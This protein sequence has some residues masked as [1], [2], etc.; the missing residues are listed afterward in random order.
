MN[1]LKIKCLCL[2]SIFLLG[3]HFFN[4]KAQIKVIE[5]ADK[6][7]AENHWVD[8]VY[9]QLTQK[10][11]IAQLF[12]AAAYSNRGADHEKEILKLIKDYHIGGLIFFQGGPVRQAGLTNKYQKAA[13]VPLLI[14]ID[15]E[16][17]LGMRLDSTVNFPYQMTLGA[18]QNDSL[19]YE[20]GWQLAE[21]FKRMGMHMNF[22]PVVDVNNNPS[23]P[24]INYRSFGENRFNVA[25][26]GLA[27]VRG[28]QDNGVL[29]TAK[30]FP[31]HGDTGTDSHY[32]LPVIKHSK[33][34]LDSLELFP[35]KSL[36]DGG[37]SSVMIA[38]MNVL[39]L[40]STKN[41]PSTLSRPIVTDLLKKDLGFKGLVVT[42]AMNMKGVT[43]HF[44]VGEA[45]VRAIEAGNDLL[46]FTE[47]IP[48]AIIAI[49]ESIKN[50][51]ITREDI[52]KRCKKLLRAKYRA[53]LNQLGSIDLTNL[54]EDLNSP[55]VRLINRRL[56]RASLTVLKNENKIIPVKNLD[57][58]KVASISIGKSKRTDFQKTLSQYMEMDHYQLGLKSSAG[59]IQQIQKKLASYDLVIAG[60][61]QVRKRPSNNNAYGPSLIKFINELAKSEKTIISVFR[62]AYTLD[63]YKDISKAKGLVLTYQESRDAQ[64]LA[65]QLIFGGTGASGKLPVSINDDF[66]LG[67]GLNVKGSIRLGYTLPEEMG[68][69]SETLNLRIDSLVEKAIELKA[70]PGAQVLIA[71]NGQVVFHK[72]YGF[73]SYTDTIPVRKKD[74]Y[75]MASITKV[76]TSLPILMKLIDEEKFNL[77]D[78]LRKYWPSFKGTNKGDLIFRD[79]LAHQAQLKP[80]IPYWESTIKKNGGFKPKTLKKDSSANYP[81]KVADGLF[82]HKHYKKKIYKAI[83]KSPLEAQKKYKYSGLVFYL[84]PEII[85]NITNEDFESYLYGNFYKPLGASTLVYNPYKYFP[86]EQVVPTESDFPFRKVAI[87]GRVH[88]EGA[89]MMGGISSNAG[90]FGNAN[91]MAKLFQ[92]YLNMGEYGGKRYVSEGTFK[93]FTSYQFPEN[94]NRRGLGFDKPSLEYVPNGNA[95][96]DASAES[97]GHT[98]FTGTRAWADPKHGLVYIF[99][100]NRVHPTRANT[101]L[102]QLNTR[103]DIEQVIYDSFLQH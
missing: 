80:W 97:F 21:N 2:F 88:D 27:Y 20:M 68:M 73:H 45:D 51:R 13:K 38:H 94:D 65:A 69:D 81:I 31:G 96:K 26:K 39:S 102:Y 86:V 33:G 1:R 74:L 42:D 9:N 78:P 6:M 70:T 15:A 99:L 61:H 41:L 8:S 11:R 54:V 43:K 76:T 53:G 3:S 59:S 85:S 19:I 90:L 55:S 18:I 49:E 66:K 84:L 100:S 48:K 32:D 23:N 62:N 50:G 25:S 5:D 36:I 34:R 46:E 22:A 56:T 47:N 89:A 71:K 87:H 82:L 98:G 79:I 40:D 64:E 75:D 10:Q 63:K 37:V 44:K 67:D 4:A 58:I 101:R 7:V 103:T 29:A 95:A 83:K 24:V 30:H 57:K 77:D 14:A 35:F 92:M 72:C 28:M 91:D 52:E 60:V 93:E 17:G 16:W 12:M